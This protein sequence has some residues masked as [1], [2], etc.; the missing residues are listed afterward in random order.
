MKSASSALI[1]YLN[2]LRAEPD[3]PVFIANC[4]TFTLLSGLILTYTNA[5]VPIALN[6]YTYLANSVLVDGLHYK[7]SIGLDIDQQKDHAFGAADRH[8]S[9][10]CRSCRLCATVFSMVAKSRESVSFLRA[11]RQRPSAA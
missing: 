9:K 6:G 4:F 10:A 1:S 3:A 7:C 11:G 5:D 8:G 2:G